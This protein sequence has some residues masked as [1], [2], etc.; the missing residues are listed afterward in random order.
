MHQLLNRMK[1][2]DTIF[3]KTLTEELK[4]FSK[5]NYTIEKKSNLLNE[6]NF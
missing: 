3:T 1:N 4:I 6:N 5:L 2:V